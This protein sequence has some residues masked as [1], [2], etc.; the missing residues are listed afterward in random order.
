MFVYTLQGQENRH[1]ASVDENSHPPEA[2]QLSVYIY[3]YIYIYIFGH[4][5]VI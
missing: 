5:R 4:Y 1:D 2:L 3:I